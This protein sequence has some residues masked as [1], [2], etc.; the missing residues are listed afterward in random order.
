MLEK[1]RTY[2]NTRD[3]TTCTHKYVY[4]ETNSFSEF[5]QGDMWVSGTTAWS[6]LVCGWRRWPPYMEDNCEYIE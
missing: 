4:F 3:E 2:R 6:A 5:L 1:G